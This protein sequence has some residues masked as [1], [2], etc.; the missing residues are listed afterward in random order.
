MQPL[1]QQETGCIN[2]QLHSA[3]LTDI[4]I[5]A[6]VPNGEGNQNIYDSDIDDFEFDNHIDMI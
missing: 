1:L 2:G 5:L 3:S 6:A 4:Y